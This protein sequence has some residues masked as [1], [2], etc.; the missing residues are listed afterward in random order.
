MIINNI[1]ATVLSIWVLIVMLKMFSNLAK[2]KIIW[3]AQG[4]KSNEARRL[5]HED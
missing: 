3:F 1:R 5:K 2:I 4:E